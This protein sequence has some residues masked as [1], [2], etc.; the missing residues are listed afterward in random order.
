MENKPIKKIFV[1][2]TYGSSLYKWSPIPTNIVKKKVSEKVRPFF[3][4]ATP[5]SDGQ[6]WNTTYVYNIRTVKYRQQ[7]SA[8]VECDYVQ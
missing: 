3:C 6:D 8:Y 4:N 2:K 5:G 7:R 1:L